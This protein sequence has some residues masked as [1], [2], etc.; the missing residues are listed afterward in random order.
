MSFIERYLSDVGFQSHGLMKLALSKLLFLRYEAFY[1]ELIA[2]KLSVAVANYLFCDEPPANLSDARAFAT[3]NKGLVR[4]KAAEL[5]KEDSLCRAL[6]CAAYNVCYGRYVDSGH[7]VGLLLHSF[8]GFVRALQ[9]VISGNAPESFLDP[10]Y[11]KIGYKNVE[12]LVNLWQLG[13]YRPLP[14]TPDSKMML[15]EIM[16]FSQSVEAS[17]RRPGASAKPT[18]TADGQY[19]SL[20]DSIVKEK[21]K[22]YGP[23]SKPPNEQ[24][25]RILLAM[26]KD[27]SL[28]FSSLLRRLQEW[29]ESQLSS[30]EIVFDVEAHATLWGSALTQIADHYRE[31]EEYERG[32]FFTS[33]AWELSKHPIVAYKF[34][35]SKLDSGNV[36][37]ARHS[38]RTF[39][40][41]YRT[42]LTDPKLRLANPELS[43]RGLEEL[44]QSARSLL[45]KMESWP[46]RIA[47]A[48]RLVPQG[49]RPPLTAISN[50][51]IEDQLKNCADE[52]R[53]STNRGHSETALPSPVIG[54]DALEHATGTPLL[55][56]MYFNPFGPTSCTLSCIPVPG[57]EECILGLISVNPFQKNLVAYL[58]LPEHPSQTILFGR[59]TDLFTVNG[60]LAVP[61]FESLPTSVFHANNWP[62]Q[63]PLLDGSQARSLFRA[64]Y[65]SIAEPDLRTTNEYL[66]RYRGDPWERTMSE[67][68]EAILTRIVRP[69]EA[70]RD[71]DGTVFDE[72]FDLVTDPAHVQS[73]HD[74]F[75]GAWRGAIE[76]AGRDQRAP[77][78]NVLNGSRTSPAANP[79][80]D[81]GDEEETE[82]DVMRHYRIRS[83]PKPPAPPARPE[84]SPNGKATLQE[85]EGDGFVELMQQL[86]RIFRHDLKRQN[87]KIATEWVENITGKPI[88]HGVWNVEHEDAFVRAQERFFWEGNFPNGTPPEF[89]NIK[90]WYRKAYPVLAGSP[91]AVELTDEMRDLFRRALEGKL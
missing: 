8:L 85:G 11:Q 22:N 47:P 60:H 62:A 82:E 40:A 24:A 32:L 88:V 35:L 39:I 70:V 12:P 17:E 34:A 63:S 68:Q 10:L 30:H 29:N 15:N 79:K 33:A 13:L 20:D 90:A 83:K 87:L 43:E 67:L 52:L 23:L 38:L 75:A 16:R 76:N 54:C 86:A 91:I 53:W 21:L 77:K 66:R 51:T 42:A 6:T 78:P 19:R 73:E 48:D 64:V 56:W 26:T 71:S 89:A 1:D 27:E 31:I 37:G 14:H 50:E 61:L 74:N 44:A 2:T 57:S 81:L 65:Q 59:T 5:S 18:Q 7:K 3:E 46:A 84:F 25:Q 72:W 4:S 80:A 45:V 36:E 9:E 49:L 28:N 69:E 41:E 58:L 55:R